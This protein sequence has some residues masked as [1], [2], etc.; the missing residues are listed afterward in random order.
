MKVVTQT[1]G[2]GGG[3]HFTPA[4]MVNRKSET[5]HPFWNNSIIII[6]RGAREVENENVTA[7]NL[8]YK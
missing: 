4:G 3:T 6:R 2:G 7:C 8:R 1:H 5:K